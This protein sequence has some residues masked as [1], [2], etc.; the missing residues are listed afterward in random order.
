MANEKEETKVETKVEEK[1]PVAKTPE[2]VFHSKEKEVPSEKKVETEVKEGE[3]KDPPVETKVETK[4]E[5]KVEEKKVDVEGEKKAPETYDLKIPEGSKLKAAAVERIARTAREQGLS[6]DEAQQLLVQDHQAVSAYQKEVD[7]ENERAFA[8]WT[9][10]LKADP[11]LGGDNLKQNSE[12]ARRGLEA[13]FS[14]ETIAFIDKT[15]LA[16]NKTLFRDLVKLGN[17]L[18]DDT[19]EKPNGTVPPARKPVKNAFYGDNAR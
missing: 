10:D 1:T 15:G 18:K 19:I 6:N 3:K 11:V 5:E 4:A 14:K 16:N 9:E 12:I 2:E 13:N 17:R 7:A 8:Q